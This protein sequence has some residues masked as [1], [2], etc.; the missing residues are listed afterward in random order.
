MLPHLLKLYS[1]G[2]EYVIH[3]NG[4]QAV[5]LDHNSAKNG[6]GLVTAFPLALMGVLA[7]NPPLDTAVGCNNDVLVRREASGRH[8]GA[9]C[10]SCRRASG[11]VRTAPSQI[12]PS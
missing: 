10:I 9:Y 4:T 1:N 2:D 11:L 8:A 3:W 7:G 12:S 6:T 5:I